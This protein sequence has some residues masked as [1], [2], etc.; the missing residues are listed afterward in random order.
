[1]QQVV[2]E[3]MT[4]PEH[5]RGVSSSADRPDSRT[6]HP[7]GR[8]PTGRTSPGN[9]ADASTGAADYPQLPPDERSHFAPLAIAPLALRYENGR[10]LLL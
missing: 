1:V 4:L 8:A 7:A 3:R 9:P 5:G 10:S 2:A 6:E